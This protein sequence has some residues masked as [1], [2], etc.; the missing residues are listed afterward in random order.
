[1]DINLKGNEV[2][3]GIIGL[4]LLFFSIFPYFQII[5]LQSY[6]QP[7]ALIFGCVLF[8]FSFDSLGKINVLDLISISYLALLGLVLYA[9]TCFPY[10]DFNEY[11]YLLVYLVPFVLVPVFFKSMEVMGRYYVIFIQIGL[12]LW[13]L[14]AYIQFSIEPTFATFLLG[15]WSGSAIDILNSGRGVLAFAPE[16]THHAFHI[17]S[18]AAVLVILDESPLSKLIAVLVLLSVLFLASSSSGLLVLAFSAM[19]MVFM[20]RY[21]YGVCFFVICI[22]ILMGL[23]YSLYMFLDEN[24]ESSNRIISLLISM[25]Q[26]PIGFITEDFS[27]N[28]RLGGIW[29]SIWY[30]IETG[31]LPNGM[32]YETWLS[33]RLDISSQ[34]EWLMGLSLAGPPS[35]F[36]MLFFQAGVLM[37]PFI[38][39]FVYRL[40]SISSR[41]GLQRLL[42]FSV[43]FVF[44]NQFYLS[45]PLFSL[46]Y[47]ALLYREYCLV[48]AKEE[49]T[50]VNVNAV[51]VKCEA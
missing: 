5:P 3:V 44:L 1:L 21:Y 9:L 37:V 25:I 13:L 33:A 8:V 45:A 46:V 19:L 39:L 31:G 15:K 4:G 7:Y 14:V 41:N 35:G 16:P 43:L 32:S 47:A 49:I 36:G 38:L 24:F 50:I 12:V 28:V 17:I 6:T 48:G 18:L 11:R 2:L 30:V 40:Y 26:N 23:N 29:A 22:I 27:V 51:E 42:V 10:N 34:N 20:K